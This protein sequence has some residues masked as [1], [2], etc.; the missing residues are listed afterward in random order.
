MKMKTK[1][2]N[3]KEWFD[4]NKPEIIFGAILG[5]SVQMSYIIGKR[6]NYNKGFRDGCYI[7]FNYTQRWFDKNFGTNL[8][9][10]WGDFVKNNPDKIV[11]YKKPSVWK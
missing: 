2:K 10:L 3:T 11:Y 5:V 6:V 8:V 1:L 9:Q 4:K 7:S